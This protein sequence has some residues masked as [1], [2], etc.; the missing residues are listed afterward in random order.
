MTFQHLLV[1][2]EGPVAWLEYNRPPV[3]SVNWEMAQE[4]IA[5][6][7]QLCGDPLVRV[8][9][10]ASAIEK[11]FNAGADLTI[12]DGISE[13]D[14]R[15][16]MDMT[17]GLVRDLRAA[18]KPL[19]AAIHGTAVGMGAEA[20]MHCDVRFAATTARFGQPEVNLNLVPGVSTTQSLVRLMG[21]PRA[22]RFLFDGETVSAEQAHALGMVDELVEPERLREHVQAYAESLAVK[23]PEA[24]AA[25]RHTMTGGMDLPFEQGMQLEY[26]AVV[27]LS[28]TA[29]FRE[30]VR[31]FLD[32]REP[33]WT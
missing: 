19:L 31:A 13:P 20:V 10:F 14:M 6:L 28:Q 27:R 16:W 32:K 17:H 3:N 30:G 24:L 22:I 5:A 11:Y 26:E 29:N 2:N 23:P 7:G 1:R 33:V 12:I 15:R 18:P 8:I 9:V 25:I 4:I 21:R